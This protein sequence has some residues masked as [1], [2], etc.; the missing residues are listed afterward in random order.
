MTRLQLRHY[1]EES[2]KLAQEQNLLIADDC[3]LGKTVTAIEASI[4]CIPEGQWPRVLV[5]CP[6]KVREQWVKQ[7]QGQFEDFKDNIYIV[8][9]IPLNLEGVH[10]FFIIHYD[11][12]PRALYLTN[13]VWDVII[14]DEA[15]RLRNRNNKYYC[16]SLLSSHCDSDG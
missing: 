2:V 5:V 6:K 15:H 14:A 11:A 10:G 13:Y 16:S 4:A 3:G 9:R 1:Q 8:D 12:L 7:I